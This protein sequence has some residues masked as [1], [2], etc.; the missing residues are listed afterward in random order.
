MKCSL[1]KSSVGI[2]VQTIVKLNSF[3]LSD[4]TQFVSNALI[5]MHAKCGCLEQAR[6]EFDRM[7]DRDVVSYSA[8]ITALANHGKSEEALHTFLKMTDE[9]IKPNQVTFIGVLN[10]CSQGGLVEEGLKHFELMTRNFG[11]EPLL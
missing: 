4:R 10:A 11:I 1:N 8:M 3:A 5:H 7:K 2:G 6:R 9:G